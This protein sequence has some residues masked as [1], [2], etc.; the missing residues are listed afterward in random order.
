VNRPSR[1]ILMVVR[2]ALGGALFWYVISKTGGWLAIERILFTGWIV[3]GLALLTFIGAAIEAKRLSL[4][5]RSQGIRLAVSDGYRLVAVGTL[6]N[7]CIPGGT[8]GDIVKLYYLASEVHSR[9]LEVATVL[10][11]D[12]A[13]GLFSLLTLIVGFGL[14]NLGLLQ[15]HAT[16]RALA[17]ASL[18]GFLSVA[19][20]AVM[21]CS[22]KVRSSRAYAYAVTRKPLGKYLARIS[23][24]LYAFR[25]HWASILSATLISLLGQLGLA[26]MF[27]ATAS[28]VMP[29]A[30]ASVVCF[31][32]L[33][34]TLA[35]ALPVTPGGLGVGEAAFE[36]LFG[37]VG[38][39][40]GS[41]LIVAWRMAMLPL[42]AVGATLYVM[43]VQSRR[44]TTL[45]QETL[46][47]PSPGEN[48]TLE[49]GQLS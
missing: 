39:H 31:L 36:A 22:A 13:V 16:V 19:A 3:P 44:L 32:G 42:S 18:T 28:I 12:R 26:A 24:A 38:L 5:F 45:A 47:C 1:H 6:F 34:A 11:V 27:V 46:P 37:S 9:R 48:P 25:S 7:I 20:A 40:G 23:D 4:L 35:N 2:V 14:L 43:G 15:E 49:T 33:S 30:A 8:G 21:C 29:E 41:Q 17:L 10:F